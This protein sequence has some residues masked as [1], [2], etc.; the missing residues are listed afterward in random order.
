MWSTQIMIAWVLSSFVLPFFYFSRQGMRQQY[1]LSQSHSSREATSLAST[2]INFKAIWRVGI[3]IK[4]R[5][6]L[7][8]TSYSEAYSMSQDFS[9][10]KLC[11]KVR[12]SELW[13]LRF[14]KRYPTICYVEMFLYH[15]CGLCF[16]F[17][18]FYIKK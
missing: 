2:S 17:Q 1:S 5:V 15:V 10:R 11:F 8:V 7:L 14:M 3:A 4:A 9:S 16:F 6:C 18:N 12:D 13:F